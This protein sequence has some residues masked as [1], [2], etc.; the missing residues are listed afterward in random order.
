M[1]L[2]AVMEMAIQLPFYPLSSGCRC[3]KAKDYFSDSLGFSMSFG[4]GLS[5]A[6]DL[7]GGSDAETMLLFL[8]PARVA[9][10]M[11]DFYSAKSAEVQ[12]RSHQ[13]CRCQ[14]AGCRASFSWCGSRSGT[15]LEPMV[16]MANVPIL[17]WQEGG[18]TRRQRGRAAPQ[19]STSW[20]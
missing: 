18:M 14:E 6:Q 12:G 11:F 2:H 20:A 17:R 7:E 19:F 16:L 15:A 5:N 4:F 1:A 13:L 9:L 10:T 8:L 3:C